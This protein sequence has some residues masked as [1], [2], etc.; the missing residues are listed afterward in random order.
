MKQINTLS[1]IFRKCRKT[2]ALPDKENKKKM[3]PH[4]VYVI[5]YST[6]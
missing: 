3:L 1:K 6:L 4:L 5:F 2:E